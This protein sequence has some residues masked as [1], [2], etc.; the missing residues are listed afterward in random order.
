MPA[1]RVPTVFLHFHE[2]TDKHALHARCGSRYDNSHRS[3]DS[4]RVACPRCT[5]S[6]VLLR[7]VLCVTHTK[8]LDAVLGKPQRLLQSRDSRLSKGVSVC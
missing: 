2:P 6:I 8:P 1:L 3:R 7:Q 5:V 4:L